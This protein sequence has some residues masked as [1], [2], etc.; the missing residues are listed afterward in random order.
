MGADEQK[1]EERHVFAGFLRTRGIILDLKD[2][3]QP[4]P[5]A[6]DI[7]YPVPPDGV[8]AFELREVRDS[9]SARRLDFK[10]QTEAEFWRLHGS[11][12]APLQA[13]LAGLSIVVKFRA[14]VTARA[15]MA[16]LPALIG[17]VAQRPKGSRPSLSGLLKRHIELLEIREIPL[18]QPM[19]HVSS[20]GHYSDDVISG[21][22]EKMGK[23]YATSHQLELIAW[24]GHQDSATFEL[25]R[26]D[27]LRELIR[28]RGGC[29]PFR[30]VWVFNRTRERILA[31]HPESDVAALGVLLFQEE[32]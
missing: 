25:G 19:I 23:P 30:R 1:E 24:Y 8:T 20:V 14:Q 31:L 9:G 3:Q 27:R 2:L 21:I 16:T 22:L 13:Q 7:L 11:S 10:L 18:A 4:D 6:P 15:A 5:P 32:V 28:K 26:R 12:S 17:L 29:A